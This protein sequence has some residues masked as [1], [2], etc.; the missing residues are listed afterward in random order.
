MRNDLRQGVLKDMKENIKPNY[1]AL[2]RQYN[3][4]YRTI[5]KVVEEIATDQVKTREVV[6]KQAYWSLL[7][8][9]SMI[10]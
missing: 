1:A 3:A 10:N 6:K 2:G 7:K 8:Q 5:K 4:D 9:S